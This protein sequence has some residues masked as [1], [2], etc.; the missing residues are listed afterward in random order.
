[1]SLRHQ[2]NMKIVWFH[3]TWQNLGAK[4][5]AHFFHQILRVPITISCWLPDYIISAFQLRAL[6]GIRPHTKSQIQTLSTASPS[7]NLR[8]I[9]QEQCHTL[10]SHQQILHA[11]TVSISTRFLSNLHIEAYVQNKHKWY[12]SISQL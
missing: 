4:F 1:M 7:A 9:I 8:H 2:Q 6:S 12:W 5:W 11:N 3:M 10:Q